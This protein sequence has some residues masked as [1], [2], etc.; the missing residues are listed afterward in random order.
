[1]SPSEEP[2]E[3]TNM[4]TRAHLRP[5]TRTHEGGGTPRTRC[6]SLITSLDLFVFSKL[7]VLKKMRTCEDIRAMSSKVFKVLRTYKY[8][9]I[10][11][12]STKVRLRVLRLVRTCKVMKLKGLVSKTGNVLTFEGPRR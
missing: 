2:A 5:Y 12:I 3:N 1:M 4:A 7:D 11:Y 9:I 6:K 10:I 8:I